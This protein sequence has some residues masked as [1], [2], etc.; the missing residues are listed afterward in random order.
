MRSPYAF[1][2]A[3]FLQRPRATNQVPCA[4]FS[5][6]LNRCDGDGKEPCSRR[7]G[8]T[9]TRLHDQPPE[10]SSS[11]TP[12]APKHDGHSSAIR[13]PEAGLPLSKA[14]NRSSTDNKMPLS[15]PVIQRKSGMHPFEDNDLRTCS[16]A[17][18]IQIDRNRRIRA[19]VDQGHPISDL[20]PCRI[21]L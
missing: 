9:T 11:S 19:V 15:H 3:A 6:W 14:T 13:M 16:A 21:P 18:A 7:S 1:Q 20:C 2:N 17:N 12:I 10:P 4:R 8:R 5:S